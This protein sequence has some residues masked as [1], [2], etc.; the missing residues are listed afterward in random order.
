MTD[1]RTLVVQR[2]RQ[3]DVEICCQ[4]RADKPPKHEFGEVAIAGA[5]LAVGRDEVG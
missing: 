5:N 1:V 2:T 3:T 4:D